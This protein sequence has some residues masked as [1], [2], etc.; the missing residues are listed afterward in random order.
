M[1]V[2]FGSGDYPLAFCVIIAAADLCCTISHLLGDFALHHY[3]NFPIFLQ[4][5]DIFRFC[6]FQFRQMI[7]VIL[8]FL[9][10]ILLHGRISLFYQ[11]N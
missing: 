4:Y 11:K 10:E 8:R 6:S 1:D 2:G 7:L 5:H 3:V 9:E